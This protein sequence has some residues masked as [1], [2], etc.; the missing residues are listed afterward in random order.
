MRHRIAGFSD[1]GEAIVK[2]DHGNVVAHGELR[3]VSYSGLPEKG[4]DFDLE[5]VVTWTPAESLDW[6]RFPR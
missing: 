2:D 4:E 5:F 6:D 3:L 1:R